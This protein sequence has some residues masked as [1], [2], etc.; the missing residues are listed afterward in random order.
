MNSR[1]SFN[2]QAEANVEATNEDSGAVV[3]NAFHPGLSSC[4]NLSH[5]M[6]SPRGLSVQNKLQLQVMDQ[7]KVKQK[8]VEHAQ[9]N[10][11]EATRR[12]TL[13]IQQQQQQVNAALVEQQRSQVADRLLLEIRIMELLKNDQQSQYT[14]ML[15]IPMA[16]SMHVNAT[17]NL[18]Q[19]VSRTLLNQRSLAPMYHQELELEIP[20]PHNPTLG[21]NISSSIFWPQQQYPSLFNDVASHRMDGTPGHSMLSMAPS[22]DATFNITNAAAFAVSG[23]QPLLFPLSLPVILGRFDTHRC[24]LSEHQLLL[25]QQIEIFE[26]D[27]KDVDT[28]MRGRNKSISLGQV[29]IRCKHCAHVLVQDRQ[30]GSTY[31]PSTKS[32]VYQAAQNMSTTHIANGLCQYLPSLVTVKFAIILYKKQTSIVSQKTGS[33]RHHWTQSVSQLGLI[34]TEDHGIRFIRNWPRVVDTGYK[35]VDG[36]R[37]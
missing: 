26:A 22:I 11:E 28:H 10:Q 5:L 34:D 25:R 27:V 7:K 33:G 19:N 31:F 12:M 4:R 8:Q 30:K 18:L 13:A 2:N 36:L 23:L 29:G 20:T 1:S 35:I 21:D 3:K 9:M 17:S 37:H 32:G 24:N 16:T 15:A 14:P 6:L